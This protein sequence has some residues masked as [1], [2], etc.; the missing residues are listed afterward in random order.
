MSCRGQIVDKMQIDFLRMLHFSLAAKLPYNLK[1]EP[2]I[3]PKNTNTESQ[4]H[5]SVHV[6]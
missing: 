3:Q 6:L 5:G 1:E 2:E 4:L